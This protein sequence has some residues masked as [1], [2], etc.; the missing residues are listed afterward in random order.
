MRRLHLI[1]GTDPNGK[2]LA[3]GGGRPL[4]YP[5]LLFPQIILGFQ[6]RCIWLSQVETPQW[7]FVENHVLTPD[8]I[9]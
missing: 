4:D 3:R 7:N 5:S 2:M 8:Q 6:L 1:Y 9:H